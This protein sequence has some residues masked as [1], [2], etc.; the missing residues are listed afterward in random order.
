MKPETTTGRRAF[1][2]I[3]LLVVIAIIAILAAM[4]FPMASTM[5][6]R[7]NQTSCLGNLQNIGQ[8]LKLYRLDERSFP[9]A[10]YG[11]VEDTPDP[12]EGTDTTDHTFLYPHYLRTRRD[13]KCPDNPYRLDE[14]R[15]AGPFSGTTMPSA[16]PLETVKD[17][18]GD[19][20]LQPITDKAVA[21]YLFDSYDGGTLPPTYKTPGSAMVPVYTGDGVSG[22][23]SAA[24]GYQLHYRRD[25]V[26]IGSGWA[27]T[28][29]NAARELLNR[30]PEDK[31]FVTACTYHRSYDVEGNVRPSA[32]S[33]D[34][35]LFLDGHTEKRPSTQV[36]P[37][38]QPKP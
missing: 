33:V 9:P 24:A 4:I 5:R 23:T 35:V 1:T 26:S 32:N 17:A 8:A 18:N 27:P 2:L 21:Y 36:S 19:V 16:A 25:W 31:T 3:E 11:Y 30:N 29:K 10:L 34:M 20:T 28:G 22:V 15:T 14:T 12:I 38:M 7:G 13:F 6:E 37:D